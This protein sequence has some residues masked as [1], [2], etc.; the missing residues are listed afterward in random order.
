M[1]Y[2]PW[3]SKSWTRKNV[4]SACAAAARLCWNWDDFIDSGCGSRGSCWECTVSSCELHSRA[5]PRCQSRRRQH[6]AKCLPL[7]IS[8]V[9]IHIGS[10]VMLC[11][12]NRATCPQVSPDGSPASQPTPQKHHLYLP[13]CSLPRAWQMDVLPAWQREGSAASAR[14]G[15]SMASELWQV[16]EKSTLS[17]NCACHL[18]PRRVWLPLSIRRKIILTLKG[19]LLAGQPGLLPMV[20]PQRPSALGHGGSS[21]SWPIGPA[22]ESLGAAWLASQNLII[23]QVG[24]VRERKSPSACGA[25]KE[26]D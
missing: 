2:S 13:H 5:C 19:A 25:C 23:V 14:G 17:A 16:P 6:S 8:G 4:I 21:H 3:G 12:Q 11:G 20:C 1:G 22:T 26:V 15:L 10:S 18:H 9:N 24:I 7:P